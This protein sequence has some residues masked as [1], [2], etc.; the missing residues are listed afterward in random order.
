MHVKNWN[1]MQNAADVGVFYKCGEYACMLHIILLHAHFSQN[2]NYW[3][4]IRDV[5]VP[6]FHELRGIGTNF[7]KFAKCEN[8]GSTQLSFK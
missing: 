3:Y 7:S 6:M 4:E 1:R 8:C 5:L 2:V